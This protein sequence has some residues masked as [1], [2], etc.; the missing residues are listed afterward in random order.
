MVFFAAHSTKAT[1]ACHVICHIDALLIVIPS[2]NSLLK[3]PMNKTVTT[4]IDC[5][6]KNKIIDPPSDNNTDN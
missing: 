4:N 3:S 5:N 2:Y 6:I 1:M